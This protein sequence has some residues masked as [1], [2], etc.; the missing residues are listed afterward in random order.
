MAVFLA[1]CATDRSFGTSPDIEVTDLTT[2]PLTQ[3]SYTHS[4][5]PF[6]SVEVLVLQDSELSGTYFIDEQGMLQF[7]L[8]GNLDA[9][10]LSTGELSRQITSG[11]A[12]GFIDNPDVS[13]RPTE[14]PEI[15]SLSFGGQVKQPGN[16][17]IDSATTLLRGVNLAGG[18]TD[19]AKSDDVLILRT[20]DGQNYIGVYNLGAIERGN[21]PD[22]QL[23]PGDIIMVGDSPAKRRLAELL[24]YL[25]ILTTGAILFDRVGN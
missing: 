5:K 22:P 11:L 15:A 21:Y 3:V 12:N 20:V 16:Y 1:G 17:P 13:L 18:L 23:A 19:F 4:F 10:G 9:A 7:P 25:S 24:P 2:L 8:L 6:D 14:L